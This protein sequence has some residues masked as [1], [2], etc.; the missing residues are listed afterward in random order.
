VSF[1]FSAYGAFGPKLHTMEL[2]GHLRGM[3]CALAFNPGSNSL[4]FELVHL[5]ADT[6][7][8]G[9]LPTLASAAI[10]DVGKRP[11]LRVY[12]GREVVSAQGCEAA[13]MQA[14]VREALR[15]LRSQTELAPRMREVA[16]AAVRVVHGGDRFGGPVEA[17]AEVR[18]AIEALEPLAPL[19]NVSSLQVLEVLE[20]ELG[21]VR[22][23]VCFDTAFHRTV[24]EVAW[25][26]P[27][28]RETADRFG[29]RKFGFHGLS[30]RYM[31]EQYARTA[32]KKASECTMVT[33]HLESGSSA[34]AI[35]D[36]VSVDTTMGLTPLEGLMMGSRCG[37]VDPAIVPFLMEKMDAGVDEVMQVLEK[38]SG[39]LGIAGG[40]LD[41]REIVKRDDRWA[42]LALEMYGYRV[43]LA[44]G[45]YLA[46][47]GEECEAVVFGGGIGEDSPWLRAQVCAGLGGWGLVLD[48]AVNEKAVSGQA[49]ISAEGSRRLAWSMPVEEGLEM[50]WECMEARQAAAG[51]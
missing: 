15:W 32:G 2:P 25:R 42:K 35:R 6:A 4:K 13:D 22:R 28:E 39:L 31:L 50:V 33:L 49:R 41:T 10:D 48:E 36:G 11:V 19:H 38:K 9:D 23:M 16:F 44:V 14:A 43:R 27:I 46:A 47:L 26:Y 34:C 45:A 29:V 7:V 37:S 24:P 17:N 3:A 30:H 12:R 8:A 18:R 20:A 21:D 40:T 5:E 1:R 51:E